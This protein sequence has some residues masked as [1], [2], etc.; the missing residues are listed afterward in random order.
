MT[1]KEA[2][3]E[4]LISEG[5]IFLLY[6]ARCG[7][8]YII[9][10]TTRL[11]D[12]MFTEILR[13]EYK[14]GLT[15]HHACVVTTLGFEEDTPVGAAIVLEYINGTTLQQFLTQNPI[16]KKQQKQLIADILE[17]VDYLH[18]KG[19]LH[20]D[21]KPANIIITPLGA[22]RIIDFGL[23][24]S[25][26]S[27]YT[28]VIGGSENYTAP[29]ILNGQGHAGAASDIYSLGTIL[30]LL[31][32]NKHQ[33]IIDKCLKQNPSERYQSIVELKKSIALQYHKWDYISLTLLLITIGIFA[34]SPFLQKQYT[35][36]QE[37]QYQKE[38]SAALDS[39]YQFMHSHIQQ[40]PYWELAYSH[41]N[42]YMQYYL[43][44]FNQLN[45]EVEYRAATWVIEEQK[46]ETESLLKGLPSLNTLPYQKQDSLLKDF[47]N[48]M[49]KK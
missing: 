31:W 32:G 5:S 2:Y 8:K 34:V 36:Y 30:P 7:S 43:T 28:G 49:Q 6:K 38:F 39:A 42:T 24:A 3:I 35:S 45:T 16:S 37:K 11:K 9:L 33:K 13:R 26:D 20:N 47:S 10:K 46:K 23:S 1:F 27:I 18:H 22:A 19:V 29:E 15:L 25:Y 12:A 41:Y 21:L 17:G 48:T 14:I 44:F 40:H 4:E